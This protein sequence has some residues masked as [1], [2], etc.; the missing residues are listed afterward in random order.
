VEFQREGRR[1]N[2]AFCRCIILA[3]LFLTISVL[4]GCA[5]QRT[6]QIQEPFKPTNRREVYI[7]SCVN[8]SDFKGSRDIAAEATR[9]FEEKLKDAG[10]FELTAD[11]SLVLT[12]DIERFAEGSALKRWTMP[13]WGATQAQ[14]VV[15]VWEKPG[16]K[17]LASFRSEAT[18]KSGGLYTVGADRY[19]FGVAFDDIVRQLK[20][21]VTGG[22][23]Q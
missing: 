3:T 14:V 20:A 7:E 8:R 21:W 22:A 5:T 9:V 15:V 23:S 19:I 18:V 10:L 11:A 17:V 2:P 4:S 6:V 12:C 1:I 13:G 16:Y